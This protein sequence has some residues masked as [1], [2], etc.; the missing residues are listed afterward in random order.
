MKNSWM[1]K[2]R[3]AITLAA[4]MLVGVVAGAA[5]AGSGGGGDDNDDD[6]I[7]RQAVIRLGSGTTIN[8]FN[9]QY[10]TT[11]LRSIAPRKIYLLRLPNNAGNEEV[12]L[13]NLLANPPAGLRWGELNYEGEN[14]EG[15]TGSFY[16]SGRNFRNRFNTQFSRGRIGLQEA[17][18]QSTGEG[19]IVG[20]L[21]TGVDATHELLQSRVLDN[22][23]NF[24]D[25]N[26]NTAEVENNID[27]DGD[28]LFDESFGHGTFVAGL[29]A[30]VAPDAQILPV[31]VLNSDGHGDGFN[32]AAGVFYAIDQGADVINMSLG[33]TYSAQALE[34]ALAEARARGVVVVGAAGNQASEIEE[35][36]AMKDQGIGVVATD[37]SD[38]KADFSNYHRK[39][40]L[41]APGTQVYSAIPQNA[42][43]HTYAL[44]EGTSMSTPLVA[45]TAAL[46]VSLH[47]EWPENHA[48]HA[49]VEATLMQ[50]AVD[51]DPLNPDYE[52]MLGSGRLDAAAAMQLDDAAAVWID[53][54][55]IATGTLLSGDIEELLDDDAVALTARSRAGFN[56][57]DPHIMEARVEFATRGNL[58][59][60]E[61]T[62][63]S[64]LSEP[65][66]AARIRLR[67]W[68]TNTWRQVDSHAIGTAWIERNVENIS[69]LGVVRSSDG[70]LLLSIRH[71][72][73]ATFTTGQFRSHIDFVVVDA[74]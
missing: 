52:R 34:D 40:D 24:V 63:R 56:E 11:T 38:L 32:F 14:G 60:L 23:F 42:Q 21:D 15:R 55:S 19:T 49:L 57:N 28:G 37:A 17:Q 6:Y 22:G 58:D 65:G 16:V 3:S 67:K 7:A 29:I 30:M 20:V 71:S 61:L 74:D 48:R 45:G 10:G 62:I 46:L 2:R 25:N 41:S 68:T 33:S 13:N 12:W 26:A 66:G 50:S 64:R 59:D 54:V 35:F 8:Q 39:A 27:E 18:T 36:P 53:S 9:S 1:D 31:K 47:P 70:H 5:M 72:M 44:W 69:P 73:L 4:A 51:I 43:G